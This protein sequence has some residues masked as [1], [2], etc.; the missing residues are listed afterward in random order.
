MLLFIAFGDLLD[1]SLGPCDLRLFAGCGAGKDVDR[2]RVPCK[3]GVLKVVAIGDGERFLHTEVDTRDEFEVVLR[4]R[5]YLKRRQDRVLHCA[6]IRT[7]YPQLPQPGAN[8][9]RR[10]EILP[11]VQS[12]GV[13][14]FPESNRRQPSAEQSSRC[15][16]PCLKM[17]E[18]VRASLRIVRLIAHMLVS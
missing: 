4:T 15:R 13:F 14:C 8:L 18:L 2:R 5:E 16:F 7:G 9:A 1:I 6:R 3:M 10:L 11:Q 17:T 12:E